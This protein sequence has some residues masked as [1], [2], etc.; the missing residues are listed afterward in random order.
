MFAARVS[1]TPD[2]AAL[3]FKRDSV[4]RT[5]TWR[6]W[7]LVSQQLAAGLCAEFGIARGE[8]VGLLA[9]TRVEWPVC[10]LAIAMTGAI[11]VPI[12]PDGSPRE[13]AAVL[14]DSEC[15]AVFV[16]NNRDAKQLLASRPGLRV[17]SLAD[18][19]PSA[20]TTF[21]GLRAA[22]TRA[23]ADAATRASLA[24]I[25][26]SLVPEDDLTW[27]YTSGT[28]G[29]PKGAVLSHHNAM[30]VAWALKSAIATRADDEQLM[31]L[32]LAHI[33]ARH[34]LWAAIT[35]GTVTSFSTIHRLEGDLLEVAPTYLGGVPRMFEKLHERIRANMTEKGVIQRSAFDWCVEIGRQVSELKQRGQGVPAA[36]S[37]KMAVADRLLFAQIRERFG[38]RIRFLIS[39]SAP[40][41]RRLAEF[42]H[43]AGVLILEGYGLTETSGAIAV[44]R[45]DRF[46]F[47]TVG[48]AIPGA[49]IR[50][51]PDGEILV[52]AASV[53]SRYRGV[54]PEGDESPLDAQ[55][56]LHTGDRGEI[57]AGYVR[58]TGR[59]K[60]L[61][62]TS[63]G[64]NIA[65]RR[66]EALLCAAPGIAQAVVYGDRKPYLVALVSLDE[67]VMMEISRS[68]GLACESYAELAEHP[69][70]RQLVQEHVD[71]LN[72]SLARYERIRRF[73]IPHAP[74]AVHT[75]ELT[76]SYKVKRRVVVER[77]SDRLEN[78]YAAEGGERVAARATSEH[79][80]ERG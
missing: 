48:P 34:M 2:R 26:E 47:G 23:L 14:D 35:T 64:K 3:R 62:I 46:R 19:A 9:P 72:T 45:P 40:L 76:A 59:E 27:V 55:G 69:R 56:W 65:P 70:I 75:G 4:W 60:D 28:T 7:E 8:R 25:A 33:F 66:I 53:M 68:E 24:E 43:A 10:E 13:V 11:S 57:S 80:S 29:R 6:D 51:A 74:F 36:L 30:Y 21:N 37:V 12:H 63:T 41:D 1:E 20:T 16:N 77:Y 58:I 42:F 5:L 39:G 78:L 73:A 79:P 38:G 31:V 50:I 32:P 71:G 52:R 15:S 67:E 18:N 17:I 54:D 22:G 49:E 61:V 44:N